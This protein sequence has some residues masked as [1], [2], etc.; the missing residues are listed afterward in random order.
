MDI[1][2]CEMAVKQDAGGQGSPQTLCSFGQRESPIVSSAPVKRAKGKEQRNQSDSGEHRLTHPNLT[3][4]V[5][6]WR[7]KSD[8]ALF[9]F[10]PVNRQTGRLFQSS[11][12]HPLSPTAALCCCSSCSF[13]PPKRSRTSMPLLESLF[14]PIACFAAPPP[15]GWYGCILLPWLG[16]AVF[17]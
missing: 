11:D 9:R 4:Q 16:G 3:N 10:C 2:I 1:L 7:R 8:V 13:T 5:S 6:A 15:I 12:P 14:Y 17:F